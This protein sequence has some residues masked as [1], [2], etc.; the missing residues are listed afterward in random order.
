MHR[1]GQMVGIVVI[2]IEIIYFVLLVILLKR[3]PGSD[4]RETIENI[5]SK[6]LNVQPVTAFMLI[7]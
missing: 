1:M 7:S 4:Q 5:V 3:R 6:K 2:R